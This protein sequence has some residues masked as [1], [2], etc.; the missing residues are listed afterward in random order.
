MNLIYACLVYLWIVP[1][2]IVPWQNGIAIG[3]LKIN[4]PISKQQDIREFY[5]E[6]LGA[7]VVTPDG[8]VPR[9]YV[10]FDNGIR[11]NIIY[12]NNRKD[13]LTTTQSLKAPWIKLSVNRFGERR[14]KVIN[15]GVQ[16]IK[17]VPYKELYFQSPDGLVYRMVTSEP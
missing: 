7:K 5:K 14:A 10:Q 12:Q 16:V 15:F 1:S 6:V 13:I 9:D 3:D 8:P 11:I 2:W 17:E 4:A